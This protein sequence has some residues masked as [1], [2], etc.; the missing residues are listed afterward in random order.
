MVIERLLDIIFT[1]RIGKHFYLFF[2]FFFS[3]LYRSWSSNRLYGNSG[4]IFP[5]NELSLYNHSISVIY[6]Y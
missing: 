5:F 3:F 1:R 2:F 4:I 6:L